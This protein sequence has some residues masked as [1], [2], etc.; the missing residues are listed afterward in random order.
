MDEAPGEARKNEI[1]LLSK[2][3]EGRISSKVPYK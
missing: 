1:I 3:S 2:Y